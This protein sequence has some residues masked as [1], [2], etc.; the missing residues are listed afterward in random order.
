MLTATASASRTIRTNT[1]GFNRKTRAKVILHQYGMYPFFL[2]LVIWMSVFKC[3]TMNGTFW[4]RVGVQVMARCYHLH[5]MYVMDHLTQVFQSS[6]ASNPLSLTCTLYNNSFYGRSVFQSPAQL[7]IGSIT[8]QWKPSL[9]SLSTTSIV[10]TE[11]N[12]H[13]KR[14]SS[15]FSLAS[16]SNAHLHYT[17]SEHGHTMKLDSIHGI[18]GCTPDLLLYS[19]R[20]NK[21]PTPDTNQFATSS[22]VDDDLYANM[23]K[24]Q[25]QETTWR[26]MISSTKIRFDL[27]PEKLRSDSPNPLMKFYVDGLGVEYERTPCCTSELTVTIHDA[28]LT[29]ESTASNFITPISWSRTSSDLNEN[30]SLRLQTSLQYDATQQAQVSLFLHSEPVRCYFDQCIVEHLTSFVPKVNANA[31]IHLSKI[32]INPL[33]IMVDYEPE[34]FNCSK[35]LQ[36]PLWERFNLLKFK[37]AVIHLRPLHALNLQNWNELGQK[38][39]QSWAQDISTTHLTA[40]LGEVAPIPIQSSS[41]SSPIN[42]ILLPMADCDVHDTKSSIKET[43]RSASQLPSGTLVD[44]EPRVT[45]VGRSMSKIWSGTISSD[46]AQYGSATIIAVLTRD[47][48]CNE[49]A[50][51]LKLHAVPVAYV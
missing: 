46:G 11:A 26:L 51:P 42:L 4:N 19:Y 29:N 20:N 10:M 25:A 47:I 5:A 14:E 1:L 31:R 41:E 34:K 39:M 23:S 40:S 36:E 6:E 28:R 13:I 15:H 21:K 45:L 50:N 37:E 30:P 44:L 9:L 24:A 3:M 17:Y 33:E 43:M 7:D 8:V 16:I 12:L 49:D 18:V 2:G 32:D 22:R 38:M 48:P 35:L 27:Y